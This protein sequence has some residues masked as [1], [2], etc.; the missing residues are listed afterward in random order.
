M[1]WSD[2]FEGPIPAARG[3]RSHPETPEDRTA[4]TQ[5][6]TAGMALIMAAEDRG[7]LLPARVGVLRAMIMRRV[8]VLHRS[9]RDALADA[10]A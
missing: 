5:W 7:P 2:E 6:H 1:T 8:G 9:E 4:I 3:R 10:E